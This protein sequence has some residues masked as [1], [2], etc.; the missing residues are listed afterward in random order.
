MAEMRFCKLHDWNFLTKRNLSLTVT[1]GTDE[2]QLTA[3]TIGYTMT[4]QNVKSV[5]D[6]TTGIYLRKV[7]LS[8]I[9]RMDPQEISGSTSQNLMMWAEADDQ[10]IKVYPLNFVDT[11]LKIDGKITPSALLTLS[12]YP[13]IPYHY[14]ETFINYVLA[15]AMQRENDD[16]A[17]A[18]MAEV[19]QLIRQDLLEELS[20]NG[21]TDEPRI[22][23]MMEQR[24]DGL[25]PNPDPLNMM[26]DPYIVY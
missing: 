25:S 5:F 23:H 22:K 2:Y 13:T 19:K 1:S 15:I 20:Q 3:A 4:S 18:K 9:R 8:S 10:T 14:Q 26:F 7:P 21:N 6:T 16:R 12:N 24:L 11:T 17:P